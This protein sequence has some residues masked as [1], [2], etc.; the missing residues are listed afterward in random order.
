L[1]ITSSTFEK[2]I[3]IM[4][5]DFLIAHIYANNAGGLIHETNLPMLL[6]EKL[7]STKRW[8]KR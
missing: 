8:Q 1:D 2:T 3:G 6:V 7:S 4:S 5:S